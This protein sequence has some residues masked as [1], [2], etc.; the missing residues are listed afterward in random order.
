MKNMSFGGSV[1]AASG[2]VMVVLMLW[3]H[4]ELSM[5]WAISTVA[6]V[7]P[8]VVASIW[9]WHGGFYSAGI[10][11]AIISA[12][13]VYTVDDPIRCVLVIASLIFIAVPFSVVRWQSVKVGSAANLIQDIRDIHAVLFTLLVNWGDM[14]EGERWDTL[15]R[16][17][18]KFANVFTVARGWHLLAQEKDSLDNG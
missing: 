18:N 1:K 6:P 5:Y 14:T 13:V 9:Y 10:S 4:Y 11:T 2:P 15:E 17:N 7:F 3:L 8:I 16:I 12:Y